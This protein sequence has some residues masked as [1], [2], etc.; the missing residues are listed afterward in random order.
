M[1]RES[2]E[3]TTTAAM[4]NEHFVCIKVDR[5]ER[6]DVDQVYQL[7]HQL[8][9]QR[10]GGWPLTV[11]L[12]HDRRP[13]FAGTYFPNAPRYGMPTFLDLLR[14]ISGAWTS[15]RNDVAAQ[16]EALTDAL[17]EVHA[18]EAPRTGNTGDGIDALER[19]L[20]AR[21][22]AT[23]GGFGRAP[24]FPNT[25]ALDLLVVAAAHGSREARD[26]VFVTLD[27]MARGG[28]FDHLGGGFARYSTDARW[29]VPHFEKMLYDNALLARLYLDGARLARARGNDVERAQRYE[30]VTRSTLDY[31]L[32]EMTAPEGTFYSAQDA[33][34]EGVEGRF[35]AWTYNA[36]TQAVGNADAPLARAWFDVTPEGNWEHGQN[37]LWTPRAPAEVAS[38]V[39]CSIE[40][41]QHA[42]ARA[43]VRLFEVRERRVKPSLDDKCLVAW[44]ALM[45]SALIDAGATLGDLRYVDAAQRALDSWR[46]RAFVQQRLC[47]ALKGNEAYGDAF[48]DDYAGLANAALDVF[49]ATGDA[50]SLAFARTLADTL[51][52]HFACP[53]AGFY[54]TADDAEVVLLRSRDPHD[55][56]APGGSGLAVKALARLATLTGHAPYADAAQSALARDATLA[57]ENPMGMGTLCMEVDRA[58]RGPIEVIVM[59]DAQREE[60]RAMLR[61]ARA[62][63]LAHR[64]IFC[65]RDAEHGRE[66]GIDVALLQGRAAGAEGAPVVY[67]CRGASCEMP[68][69]TPDALAATLRRVFG[70]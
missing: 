46:E 54:F 66:V 48:L 56:A 65:V 19:T 63:P 67:V 52:S 18:Q 7:A 2:F 6:P 26:A 50:A 3:D 37:V 10:A 4:L 70:A 5:E 32:R 35:F 41:L 44:N 61:E 9:T 47:H 38:A 62:W 43:R 28:I 40:D 25:L 33:D 12:T 27:A 64:V 58:R 39:A 15:R 21:I 17:R 68:V 57:T 51:L 14:A 49:E 1:E 13:F 60:T 69:R 22:D 59:G 34:S 53:D 55:H 30:T 20:V 16:A 42:V 36:F 29:H 23:Q 45:I 31:V 8:L 24:K 11:F